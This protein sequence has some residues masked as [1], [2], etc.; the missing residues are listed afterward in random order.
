MEIHRSSLR[1]QPTSL[2][3]TALTKITSVQSMGDKASSRAKAD[4]TNTVQTTA[5][6]EQIFLQ[7]GVDFS[8]SAP[9]K[10]ALAQI[11]PTKIQ[12][13]LNAYQHQ[14]GQV[15]QNQRAVLIAGI[16]FYA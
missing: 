3:T 11:M 2:E 10:D 1:F 12:A 8:S 7:M 9:M 13:A 16:D 5:E 15:Q 4:K 14:R 6:M